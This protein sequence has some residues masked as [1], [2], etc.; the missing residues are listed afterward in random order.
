[1]NYLKQ[2][3]QKIKDKLTSA[4][5]ASR[6]AG[7]P[8]LSYISAAI[9]AVGT[10]FLL[11]ISVVYLWQLHTAAGVAAVAVIGFANRFIAT[12]LYRLYRRIR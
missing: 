12:R 6:I 4:N 7:R 5:H 9:A 2:L 3:K 1:M 11:T 10:I 8:T